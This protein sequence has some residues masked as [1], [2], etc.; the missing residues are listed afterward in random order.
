MS[1]V[2][3]LALSYTRQLK[4]LDS[5]LKN[6]RVP[7]AFLFHGPDQSTCRLVADVVIRR[8]NDPGISGWSGSVSAQTNADVHR[9]Q[10]LP[11]KKEI[12]I[13]QI[14]E[15]RTFISRSAWGGRFKAAVIEEAHFLSEDGWDALLKTLEEPP[16][17]SVIFLLSASINVIPKTI[18]SR[19]LCLNFANPTISP[20]RK[21]DIIID[22]LVGGGLGAV[23]CL[24]VAE[25]LAQD[26]NLPGLIDNWLVSLRQQLLNQSDRR[27][28]LIKAISV[29]IRAK[30]IITT[31]N[32]NPRLV[33]E[34]LLLQ[35]G[36]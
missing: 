28:E 14:R 29:V 9:V 31:T 21:G 2:S 26:A 32:A 5:I 1:H 16:A 35:L 7:H 17:G 24:A 25:K 19:A 33:M 20:S 10:K 36:C 4:Y 18:I 11:D 12:G 34:N 6:G 30:Q 22:K 23:E 8:F 27:A 13:G 3:C 15:L